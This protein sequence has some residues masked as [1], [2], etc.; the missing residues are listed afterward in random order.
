MAGAKK[1]RRLRQIYPVQIPG[2]LS[3]IQHPE[4]PHGGVPLSLTL[5]GLLQLLIDPWLNM[6]LE[7][8]AKIYLNGSSSPALIKIIEPPELDRRFYMDLP[9]ALLR[10]GI[11]LVV[12]EVTR[13]SDPVPESSVPLRVLYHTPRP[14]GEVSGSGDNPNLLMTLPADVIAN[15][16]DAARAAEGVLVQLRYI[17]MRTAD[18][19]TFSIDRHEIR[20][21]VTA[22]EAAAGVAVIRLTTTDFLQDNPRSEWRFRVTDLLGNS[23]GPLAI[24][25]RITYVDVHIR[26]PVLDLIPPK[27]LEARDSNGTVLNFI[28]D[29]YEAQHATVEVRY[30]GSAGGQSVKLYC[31]GRNNTYGSEIQFMTTVNQTLTFRVPRHEIVDSINSGM[32]FEYTVRLSGSTEDLPSKPLNITITGQKH[33]LPEPTLNAAKDNLRTYYPPLEATYSV[34]ISLTVGTTRYDSNETTITQPSYTNVAVPPSWLTGNRGKLGLFNFT[35]KRT[36]SSDPIIFSWYLR[37]TL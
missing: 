35:L 1:T 16:I 26:R 37:V 12:L 14:G 24:W 13:V 30:P 10:D 9:A 15:G 17:H 21:A 22:A 18:I 3:P 2:W 7:D 19:I 20:H 23:S 11:N 36:G 31:L 33:F 34:R 29:F 8:S 28:R 6:S 25:S 4:N 27:V 5:S 32:R